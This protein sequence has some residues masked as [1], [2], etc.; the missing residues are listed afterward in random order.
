MKYISTDIL[1]QIKRHEGAV[2]KN[3]RHIVYQDSLGY[4]TIGY[5]RLLSR[6]LSDD[7]AH[8]LLVHDANEALYHA[9]QFSWFED[10]NH[11]R[12]GVII[13]M[14]FNL[15]LHGFKG[16]RKMIRALEHGLFNV[17]AEEM[18]DSKWAKQVGKRAIELSDQMKKGYYR[19]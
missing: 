3:N 10:L 19:E 17:A 5:G 18:M 6:G 15:G 2:K 12:Q 1:Q 9:K 4:D 11:A 8:Q 16:F 13:N 14:I 7:E